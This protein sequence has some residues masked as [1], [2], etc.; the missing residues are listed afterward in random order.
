MKKLANSPNIQIYSSCSQS[1]NSR[2]KLEYLDENDSKLVEGILNQVNEEKMMITKS[3]KFE[4]YFTIILVSVL[5]SLY[6][7]LILS[8]DDEIELVSSKIFHSIL[9]LLFTLVEYILSKSNKKER[10]EDAFAYMSEKRY[11]KV[12]LDNT[13]KYNDRIKDIKDI[14]NKELFFYDVIF[15]MLSFTSELLLYY[16]LSLSTNFNVNIGTTYSMIAVEY[17]ILL[18]RF[19]YFQIRFGYFQ[20]IGVSLLVIGISVLFIYYIPEYKSFMVIGAVITISLFKFIKFCI[21]EYIH[22]KT[23][24]AKQFLQQSNCVD[25]LIGLMLLIFILISKKPQWIIQDMGNLMKV[26]LASLFYY[27]ALRISTRKERHFILY[28]VYSSLNFIFISI[29]D[30]LINGRSSSFQELLTVT[31]LSFSSIIMFINDKSFS[32]GWRKI[33][34]S[35]KAN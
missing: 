9:I 15:G 5:S 29:F 19:P 7:C 30:Y 1:E 32:E 20:R 13:Q 2:I 4:F 35:D 33:D 34:R 26:V 11:K 16:F 25:G 21:F 23:R 17:L 18:M 28:T 3:K 14:D 12:S 31:F 8:M 22:D 27:F 24:N 6:Y 10:D